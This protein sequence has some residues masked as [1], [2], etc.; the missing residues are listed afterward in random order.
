M[1]S[2]TK[3]TL[4]TFS[5]LA[6]LAGIEHAAGE[7]L[8]GNVAVEGVVIASWQGSAFFDILAGEPAMTLIPNMLFT[9]IMALLVSLIFLACATLYLDRKHAGLVLILL[10]IAMLLVGG[11]F[12]PPL[13]GLI[14]G[15]AATRMHASQTG[16]RSQR[17]PGFVSWLGKCWPW[18]FSTCLIAWLYLFPGSTLLAYFFGLDNPGL[19]YFLILFAFGSL[20]LAIL[21][22]FARDRNPMRRE[23][24]EN[25]GL[26]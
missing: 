2:A 10:S 25:F 16:R 24:G 13:L 18:I 19:V 12:G 8:Q 6:A 26:E 7:I 17:S 22:G 4:S 14:V 3:V 9:G 23:P 11:G 21:S 15:G 5:A 1:K 20:L